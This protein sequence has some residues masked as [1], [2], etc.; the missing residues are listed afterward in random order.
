MLPTPSPVHLNSPGTAPMPDS[1][2]LIPSIESNASAWQTELVP[3]AASAPPASSPDALLAVPE[4]KA[5]AAL[6]QHDAASHGRLITVFKRIAETLH[7]SAEPGVSRD[8][9]ANSGSGTFVVLHVPASDISPA[10]SFASG[11]R[12]STSSM[13]SFDQLPSSRAGNSQGLT[14][15]IGSPCSHPASDVPRESLYSNVVLHIL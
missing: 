14:T 1:D 11:D 9:S 5:A 8:S 13:Q 6:P 3:T 2:H 4:S 7:A 12:A 15:V 10:Q